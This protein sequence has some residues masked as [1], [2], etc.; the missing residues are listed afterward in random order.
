MGEGSQK[1]T[2]HERSRAMNPMNALVHEQEQPQEDWQAKVEHLEQ[3]VC[4]LL[5]KNQTLRMELQAERAKAE[6][7]SDSHDLFANLLDWMM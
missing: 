6:D 4:S 3:C 7:S 2:L 5:L 1:Q